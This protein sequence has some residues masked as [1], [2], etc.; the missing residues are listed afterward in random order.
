MNQSTGHSLSYTMDQSTR[1][2][3]TVHN[4]SDAQDGSVSRA[5][6][7]KDCL[8]FFS[9]KSDHFGNSSEFIKYSYMKTRTSDWSYVCKFESLST[10]TIASKPRPSLFKLLLADTHCLFCEDGVVSCPASAL[11]PTTHCGSLTWP[12]FT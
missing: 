8:S 6:L 10:T 11:S 5:T 4:G 12:F 3:F 9:Q 7:P 2:S 1:C